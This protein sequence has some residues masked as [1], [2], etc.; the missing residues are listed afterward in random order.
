MPASTRASLRTLG[1]VLVGS[2]L[3]A[4]LNC[5]TAGS[6]LSLLFCRTVI[7]MLVL[8]ALSG[9]IVIFRLSSRRSCPL[10]SAAKWPRS[11]S[12]PAVP[13][14]SSTGL[15]IS[16]TSLTLL[17]TL[18]VSTVAVRSASSRPSCAGSPDGLRRAATSVVIGVTLTV[19]LAGRSCTLTRVTSSR[20][21]TSTKGALASALSVTLYWPSLPMASMR[22]TSAPVASV[23]VSVAPDSAAPVATV[24]DRVTA[25]VPVVAGAWAGAGLVVRAVSLL[26][27]PPQA[28]RAN[29]AALVRVSRCRRWVLV[30][31]RSVWR[32]AVGARTPSTDAPET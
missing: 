14:A 15:S 20:L 7:W 11:R 12:S 1:S 27:P 6:A 24:P 22:P 16:R 10:P 28:A 17:L 31:G 2:G 29:T 8:L 21:A 26:P 30:M 25:V 19:P 4:L 18:A 9:V 13:V 5:T 23:T 32:E 3:S